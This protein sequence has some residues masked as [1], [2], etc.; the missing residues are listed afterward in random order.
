MTG[1]SDRA[2]LLAAIQKYGPSVQALAEKRYGISGEALLAKLVQGESGAIS[3]P[4]SAKGKVSSAGARGWAQFTSG[5]RRVAIQKYGLDPWRSPDEA[6][7]A[8]SLHL[9]GRINGSTALAGYNPGDPSYTAY[10]LNQKVGDIH[11]QTAGRGAASSSGSSSSAAAPSAV[12]ASEPLGAAFDAGSAGSLSNL[13]AGVQQ[14]APV[15]SGS[16]PT[17]PAFA[18]A[19]PLPQGYQA[20]ASGGGPQPVR[21]EVALPAQ[22]DLSLPAVQEQEVAASTAATSSGR[23]TGIQSTATA[24][25]DQALSRADAIDQKHLPYLWGGGHSGKVNPKNTGPLDCS[26]AVSAV[27]G[28]DPRVASQFEKFG[29]AGRAQGRSGINVYAKDDHV[30]MAIVVNGKE[31]FFGTSRSNAGGGAGWIPRS[32]L[33]DEYLSQFTVRHLAKAG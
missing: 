32:A 2:Q 21:Q 19:P 16:L 6:L 10:I 13:L 4:S 9:R 5:S 15:I 1:T 29:T 30:L 18:A 8:A 11:G 25:V 26:G 24:I 27:L 17:P 7:H 33:S 14:Q 22:S 20:P 31:R 3:D 28:L 23:P 12:A